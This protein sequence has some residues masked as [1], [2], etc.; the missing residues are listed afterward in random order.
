MIL[1]QWA[2]QWGIS[3][4]ALA[5]LR[6]KFGQ[7]PVEITP[8]MGGSEAA[9]INQLR[10]EASKKGL[11]LWR[12]NNGATMDEKG[13]FIRFGLANDSKAVN[14]RI[15]SSDLIGI[16]PLQVGGIVIGQ[17]VARE[18]KAANW[19]YTGTK[20]EQAQLRYLQLVASLG[21]DAQ[22]ATGEGTL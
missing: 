21:G 7:I 5:D 19:K 3:P 4:E 9:V 15:K 6:Q 1:D 13:N 12:N 17:F 10:L 14:D 2:Q 22:F 8:K 16:R 11:R 18:V 20:R